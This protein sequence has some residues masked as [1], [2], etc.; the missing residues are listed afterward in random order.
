MLPILSVGVLQIGQAYIKSTREERL[1][2][3]K[4]LQVVLPVKDIIW[5]EDGKEL[6]VGNRM[7]DVSSF[8]IKD[9]KYHLTGIFDDDETDIA[10][11]IFHSLFSNNGNDLFH[12]ILLLQCFTGCLL[13][14]YLIPNNQR[15][16]RHLMSYLLFLPHPS[17][18][19][20]SPPPR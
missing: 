17:S 6:W 2:S 16:I 11:S 9:G 7:F 10:G 15:R 20:L 3:E 4:L 8:S 5:E 12:L 19:V 18:L 13:L 14:A 1:Q